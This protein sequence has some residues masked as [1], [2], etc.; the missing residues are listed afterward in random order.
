MYHY[1]PWEQDTLSDTFLV[2]F[3]ERITSAFDSE[4]SFIASEMFFL[5]GNNESELFILS[6]N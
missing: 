3:I 2:R 5:I 6:L 4:I 1:I